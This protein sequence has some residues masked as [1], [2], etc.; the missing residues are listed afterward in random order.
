MT[1]ENIGSSKILYRDTIEIF[2]FVFVKCSI[3]SQLGHGA[4]IQKKKFK[5]YIC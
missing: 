5:K 2:Y 1:Q 4:E 3:Y